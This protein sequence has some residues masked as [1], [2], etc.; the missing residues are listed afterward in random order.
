MN[1]T[2]L[3]IIVALPTPVRGLDIVAVWKPGFYGAVALFDNATDSAVNLTH[4]KSTK[5][6]TT[7]ISTNR[8]P[9]AKS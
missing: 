6:I 3:S 9:Q 1:S 8:S 7:Q 5:K 2:I 4:T